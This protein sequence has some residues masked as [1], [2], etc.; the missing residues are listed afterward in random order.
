ME[1][2]MSS[3]LIIDDQPHMRQLLSEE[4]WDIG[5]K[6]ESVEDVKLVGQ[7]FEDSSPDLV[8][9]DL[10]LKGFDGWEVLG[11]IKRQHPRVPVLIVTAYDSYRND[12]RASQADGYMVKSFAH[13]GELKQKIADLLAR[14]NLGRGPSHA[15]N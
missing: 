15:S 11:D 6:V 14:N 1:V 7:C 9:L 3:I 4:L 12:P 13:L 2:K 8:V 10:Y 5:C